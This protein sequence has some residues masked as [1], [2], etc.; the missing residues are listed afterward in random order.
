MYANPTI[1]QQHPPRR[2]R[3]RYHRRRK[4]IYIPNPLLLLIPLIIILLVA[5]HFRKAPRVASLN[6]TSTSEKISLFFDREKPVITGLRN[7]YTY[8]GD[9]IS[10]LEDMTATD[11]KDSSPDLSVDDSQVNLNIP[12]TYEVI[13]TAVDTSGNKTSIT[14]QVLVM[15]KK[16]GYVDTATIYEAVDAQ[17]DTILL[18]NMSAYEQVQAIY[19]WTRGHLMYSGS[20]DHTEWHQA[21]YEML[22]TGFGDCYGYFAV[23]KLMLERIGIPNIDVRKVKNFEKD[24][25]HFWSLVSLDGG[26]TYYHL[27][28][29]PRVGEGDNFLLVSDAFLD[30]YSQNHGNCH[31][32]DLSLYPAT[33]EENYGT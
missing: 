32:R 30:A 33:P 27:D 31:N 22:T 3:P 21:G 28:T 12:G 26:E 5:F 2:K 1:N 20:S 4:G 17:L 9:P 16:E 7:L 6:E 8:E 15:E 18:S 29:T 23:T 13:Y 25:D 10:Y 11:N 19:Q 14:G 24:S